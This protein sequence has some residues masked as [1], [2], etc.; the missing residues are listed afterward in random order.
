M[1]KICLHL[2]I[3]NPK[4]AYSCVKSML[5]YIEYFYI[6][7]QAC[8]NFDKAR[9]INLLKNKHGLYVSINTHYEL[10]SLFQQ[11]PEATHIMNADCADEFTGQLPVIYS[12]NYR[13]NVTYNNTDFWTKPFLIAKSGDE[14][15]LEG[16]HLKQNDFF[17]N[18]HTESRDSFYFKTGVYLYNSKN[19]DDAL[20]YL[21]KVK[22]DDEMSYYARLLISML[23][24]ECAYD[25][26]AKIHNEYPYRIEPLYYMIKHHIEHQQ[27]NDA[28]S[29]YEPIPKPKNNNCPINPNIY[30]KL[31]FDELKIALKNVMQTVA[32]DIGTF[33]HTHDYKHIHN[34]MK[35]YDGCFK[36]I[37]IGNNMGNAVFEGYVYDYEF[38]EHVNA[39]ILVQYNNLAIKLKAERMFLL[40]TKPE[41]HVISN[42]LV[43]HDS[44]VLNERLSKYTRIVTDVDL[45]AYG[46]PNALVYKLQ[47][48]DNYSFIFHKYK[49]HSLNVNQLDKPFTL[50]C[51]TKLCEELINKYMLNDNN[52]KISK[53]IGKQATNNNITFTITT[54]K[55]FEL[56]KETMY[57]LIRNIIDIE[58]IDKWLC[59][60]DNSS[61]EDRVKMRELFPFMTFIMKTP[62]EKGHAKSMNII[63]DTVTTDY[64]L[65]YEDDWDTRTK[66]E[67]APFLEYVKAGKADH[68]VLKKIAFG[69]KSVAN[70]VNDANVHNYHYNINSQQKPTIFKLYDEM[71]VHRGTAIQGGWWWPGFTLNPSIIN[72]KKMKKIGW[73]NDTIPH[74][75]FEYDY[76]ARCHEAGMVIQFVPMNI[77]HIGT[78]SSYKMN[79]TKR[80]YD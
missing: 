51:K 55:R 26:V 72:M 48:N 30:D 14:E 21:Q 12:R 23:T 2:T 22:S 3:Y 59:V 53:I 54:C 37:V 5:P 36:F 35:Y 75:I 63:W 65:H 16:C 34:F 49:S 7:D 38:I 20:I 50:L 62:D 66:F 41:F 68:L 77:D 74:D 76:A 47:Q 13:I 24:D 56:F 61:E 31:V 1:T 29:C 60:D 4:H 78:V 28:L 9:I 43:C 19:Y 42:Y 70:R 46:I 80:Y 52:W 71:T 32:I 64:I 18:I 6:N 8:L 40:Q 27:Y 45:G 33:D 17:V 67:L 39:D 15:L 44:A 58:L 79:E 25:T 73:F 11:F 69:N 10:T 57:S